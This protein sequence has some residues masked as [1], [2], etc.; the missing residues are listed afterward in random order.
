MRI[1]RIK[2]DL[3]ERGVDGVDWLR[4]GATDIS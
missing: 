4:I 3:K 1:I 2:T